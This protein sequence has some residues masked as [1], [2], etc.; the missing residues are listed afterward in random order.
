MQEERSSY[1]TNKLSHIKMYYIISVLTSDP[2]IKMD[3]EQ[4]IAKVQGDCP[5]LRLQ[6]FGDTVS[7]SDY[8]QSY[9]YD[10]SKIHVAYTVKLLGATDYRESN[11]RTGK[12]L[13]RTWK[14]NCC[15]LI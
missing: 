2:R 7:H 10:T 9:K 12:D 4:D 15:S 14:K 11:Y 5:E 13:E 3:Y 1:K 6:Y 8:V